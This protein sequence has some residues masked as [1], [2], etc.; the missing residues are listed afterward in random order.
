MKKSDILMVLLWL[1]V[2]S[3]LSAQGSFTTTGGAS[4]KITGAACLKLH[5]THWNNSGTFAA[6]NSTVEMS[7]DQPAGNQIAG[8]S[9]DV[10]HNL[11]VNRNGGNVIL[12]KDITV[13]QA[14][15]FSAGLLDLGG[16]DI[17]L[18]EPTGTLI[19]ELEASRA[20]SNAGGEI[21]RSASLNAPNQAN[22]GNIGVALTSAANPGVTLIRRGHTQQ[23]GV[24]NNGL[25][26][27]FVIQP[28]NNTGLNATLRFY[29]FDAELN[30]IPE[31]ELTLYRSNDGGVTW[32]HVGVTTRNTTQNWVEQTGLASLSMWTLGCLRN[33]SGAIIWENDGFNGVNNTT[34][35]LSGAGT[36]ND[37]SD[38]NG[39]YLV[40]IPYAT[41]NFTLAPLK[42]T[43]KLNG[44]TSADALAIQQHV[45]NNIPI[46]DPYRLVSADVNKTNSITT[47]DATI[48]N[49]ALLG[50]PSA[51]LQFKTS[52]R[53]VPQT[54]TMS[55]PPWGFPENI[56]LTGV[57]TNQTGKDFYGI[58]TGDLV[59]VWTNP[60]TFGAGEPLVLRVQ[61]QVLEAGKEIEAEFR[62]DQLNDLA[63]WQFA[64]RFNPEQL[65]LAVVQPLQALPLTLEDFGLLNISEG[66]IRTAWSQAAGL[67]LEEATPVFGLKFNVLQS[68]GKL[69]DALQLANGILPGRVYNSALAESGVTLEYSG[70]SQAGPVVATN[71]YLL[72]QNVPNPFARRTRIGFVLPEACEATLRVF[73]TGGRLLT[74]RSGWYPA[75]RNTEDFDFGS[76]APGVLYY[77]LTTQ[78]GVLAKKMAMAGR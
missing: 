52:W 50:N 9:T 23:T 3:P 74:E 60:S 10:F 35:N 45:A 54:H 49:Q 69:S 24:C 64:L 66:E 48:I 14:L 77:E 47:L 75:G 41:G 78:F 73:D 36:G 42:N 1:S 61:D 53:F 12:G 32:T 21:K 71:D 6:G 16:F 63:A 8:T 28:A 58:K 22:P 59:S 17:T 56:T 65:Q 38:T 70:L 25:K 2:I 31:N 27:Y 13:N 7:G 51:L 18:S 40:S 37:L 20:F 33:F 43:N 46:T 5:N 55:M 68:G 62:A 67:A 26:R 76:E 57:S 44:V 4:V 15:T 72:L 11:T 30:G 34:V 19:G 39:D 29:Y